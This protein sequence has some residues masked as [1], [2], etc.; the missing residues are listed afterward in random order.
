MALSVVVFLKEKRDGSI[1]TR[2]CVNGA[3]QRKIWSKEDAA[4]PTPHLELVFLVAGILAW[5]RRKNRCFDI[6]SAFPTTDTDKEVI[7]VLKGE[8]EDYLIRMHTAIYQPYAI[9]DSRGRTLLYVRL[10]KA[11]YGLMREALLFYKKFHG[12]LEAYGFVV[13]PYDPCVTNYMSKSGKKLT[14]VWHVDNVYAS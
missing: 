2:A 11:L 8:L 12:E 7:M 9:V 5:Q 6:S 4:S 3:P 13:S 10:Q 14:V 1:K